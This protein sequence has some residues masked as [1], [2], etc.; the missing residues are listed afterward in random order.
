MIQFETFLWQ[1]RFSKSLLSFYK[2]SPMILSMYLLGM[3]GKKL[4]FFFLV[5]SLHLVNYTCWISRKQ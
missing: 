2:F 1:N 4:I 3:M 5:W